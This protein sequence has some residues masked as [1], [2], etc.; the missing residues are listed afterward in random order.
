MSGTFRVGTRSTRVDRLAPIVKRGRDNRE[1]STRLCWSA[2]TLWSRVDTLNFELSGRVCPLMFY[3]ERHA[4]RHQRSDVT[5]NKAGI[6]ELL[7][8]ASVRSPST[9][10]K[11]RVINAGSVSVKERSIIG[12][13]KWFRNRRTDF[14]H[15][16]TVQPQTDIVLSFS[17][18]TSLKIYVTNAFAWNL[19]KI[20]LQKPFGWH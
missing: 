3:E 2:A 14:R 10:Q 12:F 6:K 20:Y 13:D 19:L 7:L 17:A 5:R 8:K 4:I 9:P 16:N 11:G 1:S 18:T 15:S